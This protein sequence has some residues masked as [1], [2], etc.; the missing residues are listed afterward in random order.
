LG[1]L[2]ITLSSFRNHTHKEIDFSEGLTVIWGDNGSGKTS[3][4]E[5][6]HLLSYGKSF[7]THRRGDLVK[8]AD[9]SYVVRGKFKN[10]NKID[11][12]DTEFGLPGKTR[13]KINGKYISGR[14]DQ[15]GRNPVV[16]L[17]PE[18][19]E[20]T[21]GGPSDR[22]RF[23]DRV[24]SVVSKEYLGTLQIFGRL[25]KQR[26]AALM[27]IKEGRGPIEEILGWN[28]QIEATSLKL[29]SKR[30]ALMKKY[31]ESL[32]YLLSKYDG[33]IEIGLSY[34]PSVQ[35]PSQYKEALL[36]SQKKDMLQGRTS[37]GPH[38]DDVDILWSGKKIRS[39]GSQGE[40][41][42]SLVFLKLSEMIF[43]KEQTGC[44]PILLL[45]DL[46][47]KID[48]GR[49][50]KLVSLLN[51]IESERGDSVQTVVTT[52]DIVN[53]EKSGIFSGNPNIKNHHLT[54]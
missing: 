29:W 27:R 8:N 50:K 53:I 24:F 49:S 6:I 48:H 4:L 26:N 21:K 52:T 46:F 19:Q 33:E 17:S 7:K 37:L 12:V 28:E 1:I 45:D 51:D 2:K 14:K 22:R 41:K 16:I 54:R 39:F 9:P 3:L 13:T 5:A 30:G 47:A 31:K 23:F 32:V 34:S 20:I 42:L 36:K 35:E 18:E 38:R 43:I 10:K 44:F 11:L 25:L 40:H 15:I